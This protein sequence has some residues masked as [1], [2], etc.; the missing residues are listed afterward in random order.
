[1]KQTWASH[2]SN[3][4]WLL[5]MTADRVGSKPAIISQGET[6]DYASLAEQASQIGAHLKAF[7][8]KPNDR[9]AV[10]MERGADAAAAFFGAA[11]VGA[12]TINVNET[13][14]PRQVE[15]ILNHSG[16][17][18]M[19]SS[20]S[21]IFGRSSSPVNRQSSGMVAKISSRVLAPTT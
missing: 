4:A 9:V 1:M 15:Y 20:H 3:L 12:I 17:A 2:S 14:R 21:L 7:G 18:V 19:L 13:L 16:A 8:V 10:F 6:I 5:W 11:A